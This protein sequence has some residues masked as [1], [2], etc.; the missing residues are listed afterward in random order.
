MFNCGAQCYKK[1]IHELELEKV[2]ITATKM[3]P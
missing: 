2:Q 3:I 1:D